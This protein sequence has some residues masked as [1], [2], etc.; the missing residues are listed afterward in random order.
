MNN[1]SI[2]NE[3]QT[4]APQVPHDESNPGT[5]GQ[6]QFIINNDEQQQ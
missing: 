2:L 4:V 5:A 6:G 3:A 1:K